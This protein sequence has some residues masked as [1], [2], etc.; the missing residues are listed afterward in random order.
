MLGLFGRAAW[1]HDWDGNS[2]LTPTFLGLPASSFVVNG[3]KSP[4]NLALLTAGSELR[5]RNGWSLM[6]KFDGEFAEH[7]QTYTGTVR[8][9]YLW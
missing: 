7:S 2:S 1:A 8:L 3:A 4:A 6:G 5:L 9:R